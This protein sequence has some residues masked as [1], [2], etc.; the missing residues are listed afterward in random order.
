MQATTPQSIGIPMLCDKAPEKLAKA[1]VRKSRVALPVVV[2][3]V[4][5]GIIMVLRFVLL[6]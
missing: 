1:V 6:P 2:P 3:A 5:N 4:F